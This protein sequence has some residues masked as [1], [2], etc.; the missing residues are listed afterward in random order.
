MKLSKVSNCN[1]TPCIPQKIKPFFMLHAITRMR[2]SSALHFNAVLTKK[3][4]A[5]HLVMVRQA[6]L[7][8]FML[9]ECKLTFRYKLGLTGFLTFS[10][11]KLFRI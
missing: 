5:K 9:N 7:R 8:K 11:T 3:P 1:G 6:P 4:L 2:L 10:Y